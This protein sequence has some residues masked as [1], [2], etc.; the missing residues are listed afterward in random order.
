[1]EGRA[2]QSVAVASGLYSAGIWGHRGTPH[3]R[4]RNFRATP[5]LLLISGCSALRL[6][7]WLHNWI[8]GFEDLGQISEQ[9]RKGYFDLDDSTE[10]FLSPSSQ[11]HLYL[12]HIQWGQP[13]THCTTKILFPSRLLFKVNQISFFLSFCTFPFIPQK[14]KVHQSI[15]WLVNDH[16]GPFPKISALSQS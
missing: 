3:T 14:I 15:F 10:P 12:C 11:S 1:M 2:G 6:N 13:T 16:I 7:R 4:G 8:W 5:N 9:W